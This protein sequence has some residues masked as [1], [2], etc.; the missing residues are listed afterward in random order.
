MSMLICTANVEMPD[1]SAN[2]YF[3]HGRNVV[4][5]PLFAGNIVVCIIRML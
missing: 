3:I 2:I 5:S 1:V 4:F